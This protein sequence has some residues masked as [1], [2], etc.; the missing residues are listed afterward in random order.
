LGQVPN[1]RY[2]SGNQLI[3]LLLIAPYLDCEMLFGKPLV[4]LTIHKEIKQNKHLG[5]KKP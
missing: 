2:I 5:T 4:A 1:G 3:D